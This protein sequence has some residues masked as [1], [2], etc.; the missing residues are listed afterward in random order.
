[1]LGKKIL[2]FEYLFSYN[3][4]IQIFTPPVLLLGPILPPVKTKDKVS[5]LLKFFFN[6]ATKMIA[7]SYE[8]SIIFFE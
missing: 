6:F 4:D 5:D 1:M 3:F 8:A 2:Y 7:K